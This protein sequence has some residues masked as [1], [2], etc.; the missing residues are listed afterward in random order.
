MGVFVL[1]NIVDVELD[2]DWLLWLSM[3]KLV[4]DDDGLSRMVGVFIFGS[5]WLDEVFFDD[6]DDDDD[7]VT[8]VKGGGGNILLPFEDIM[9]KNV[10]NNDNDFT[11]AWIKYGFGFLFF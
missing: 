6:D 10:D 5:R 7:V 11:N 2:K 3:L 4:L 8:I 1:D 9:I